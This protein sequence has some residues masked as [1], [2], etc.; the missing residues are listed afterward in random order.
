MLAARSESR[1]LGLMLGV[2]RWRC[3]Y[4]CVCLMQRLTGE[5]CGLPIGLQESADT[6][7]SSLNILF[8][9]APSLPLSFF[10]FKSRSS[11]SE[12][13]YSLFSFSLPASISFHIYSLPPPPPPPRVLSSLPPSLPFCLWLSSSDRL[14]MQALYESISPS[15]VVELAP[16]SSGSL[17]QPLQ[18]HPGFWCARAD[19][20]EHKQTNEACLG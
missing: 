18:L 9:L 19:L 4:V 8:T 7:A 6:S 1:S 15:A 3:S 20:L 14:L 17:H 16:L 2:C 10:G 12:S 5:T 13:P 11:S